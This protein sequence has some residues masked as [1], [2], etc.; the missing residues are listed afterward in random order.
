MTHADHVGESQ[1]ELGKKLESSVRNWRAGVTVTE[2]VMQAG[3]G[4]GS[5]S[6]VAM[7]PFFSVLILLIFLL[8]PRARWNDGPQA[9]GLSSPF[10]FFGKYLSPRI[11]KTS[12]STAA[13]D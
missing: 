6:A 1:G 2:V 10:F 13:F 5:L 3:P 12:Q 8:F 4:Q 11:N 7:F 9:G